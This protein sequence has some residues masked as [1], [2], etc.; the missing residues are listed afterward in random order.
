M[1]V[2]VVI[3]GAGLSGLAAAIRAAHFG[4]RVLVLE[5]HAS[6]GGLNG[7]YSRGG[8]VIDVGLHALTNYAPPGAR[9]AP[10]TKLLRQLRLRHGGLALREQSA[11]RIAFPRAELRFSNDPALLREEVA[12]AFPDELDGFDALAARMAD[13]RIGD[14]D[15]P[16]LSARAEVARHIRNPHLA[17]MLLCPLMYYGAAREDDLSWNQFGILW[18][19]VYAS[20]FAYPRGGMARLIELL[21]ARLREAGGEVR[22]RAPVEVMHPEGGRIA[23]VQLESG[24]VFE[25]EVVLSSAG[26]VETLR[27]CADRPTTDAADQIGRL[28]FCE[29]VLALDAPPALLGLEDTILFYNDAETFRYRRPGSLVDLDSGVLCVPPNYE[30]EDP[31]TAG[32]VRLSA[33][34]SYPAW[35]AAL[36]ADAPREATEEGRARYAAAKADVA[37][38]MRAV[39]EARAPGL[40][41]HVVFEDLFTPLTI[42]RFS[43]RLEGAVYGSPVKRWDGRSPYD[44]LFFTGTDQGFLGIVGALLSGISISNL[45]ALR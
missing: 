31:H 25:P 29:L 2:D 45:Y 32:I 28:S 1:A 37:E 6:A 17:G 4:R 39:L 33:L 43:R 18:Q 3:I 9:G 14:L 8:R 11:S 22:F 23:Q 5:A 21:L 40:S 13:F 24:E 36:G 12:R 20:G 27:L 41:D 10:L 38:R 35:R 42:A 15:P 7:T 26:A 16:D 30:G 34:A 19:S 44:N